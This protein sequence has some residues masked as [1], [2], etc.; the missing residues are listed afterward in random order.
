MGKKLTHRD[1]EN[2]VRE[3]VGNEYQIIGEYKGADTKLLMKHA[4]CGNEYLVTPYKFS[5]GRRCPKCAG[6]QRKTHEQ[7]VKEFNEV[8][9]GE[10]TLTGIYKGARRKVGVT[11]N[12]CGHSYDV[13][14]DSFLNKRTKCPACNEKAFRAKR[15]KTHEQFVAEFNLL[16]NREYELLSEYQRDDLKITVKHIECGRIY[17]VDASSFLQGVRCK[18]CQT[19]KVHESQ[20]WTQEEFESKVFEIGFGE[21]KVIGKYTLS[22]NKIEIKHLECGAVYEVTPAQFIQGSRCPHCQTSRGEL[23]IELYLRKNNFDY[24]AQ[25]KFE[26]CRYK[27]PLPFDFAILKNNK[28]VCLIEFEGRQHFTPIE[29]F[30]G[31]REFRLT[32]IRDK[33]KKDYCLKNNIPLIEIPYTVK[34][35][36][37]F[38]GKKLK[39]YANPEPSKLETV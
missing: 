19:K 36:N 23:S 29:V 34:D 30:G 1:F 14:P 9:K 15:K 12:I 3:L 11:H 31:E 13:T 27:R 32:K 16:S 35:V 17:K 5:S 28:V 10:Y 37:S 39:Y 26:D 20:T 18:P 2:R 21:Y 38:L 24:K 8:S 25:Y 33:I 22:I 7:F 6:N 4:T